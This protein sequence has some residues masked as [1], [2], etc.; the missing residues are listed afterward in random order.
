M[1]EIE[2][3]LAADAEHLPALKQALESMGSTSAAADPVLTSTYYDSADLKL[4]QNHLTLRV[5]EQDGRHIQTLKSDRPT[6]GD[7][8]TRD[9]WEDIV[10]SDQPNAA[11][12]TT[13]P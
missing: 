12:A 13:G 2:L 5:R 7:V 6:S 11:A 4:R 8:L 9:E 3:K 1:P 10:E